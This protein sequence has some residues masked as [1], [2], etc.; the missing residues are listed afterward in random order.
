VRLR[1]DLAYAGV[2]LALLQATPGSAHTLR[3]R[4]AKSDVEHYIEKHVPNSY[5]VAVGPC[6]RTRRHRAVCRAYWKRALTHGTY[7][8]RGIGSVRFRGTTSHRTRTSL[9]SRSCFYPP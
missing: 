3:I 4:D 7:Y 9:L 5:D 6:H 2:I 1:A 8:C